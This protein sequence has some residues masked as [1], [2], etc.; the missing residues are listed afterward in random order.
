MKRLKET[1]N[2][3]FNDL[4]NSFYMHKTCKSHEKV[5]STELTNHHKDYKNKFI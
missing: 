2:D 5:L 1:F 3:R 4:E